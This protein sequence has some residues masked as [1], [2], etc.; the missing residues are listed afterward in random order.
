MPNKICLGGSFNP[1][2]HAHLLCARAAAEAVGAQVVVLM[3]AGVAPH[4]QTRGDVASCEDRLAMCNR[5][6]EH[7]RGFE[8]ADHEICRAGPSFT[9]Q[10]VRQL[11]NE[12]WTQVSWLIGADMLNTLPSWH[13]ATAL[14]EEARLLIM[15]RPGWTFDWDSLGPQFQSLRAQVVQVPQIDISATDIRRRVRDGLPIDCMT[16]PAVCRY[17]EDRKLYR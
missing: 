14:I 11:K 4:K 10:T 5:A 15:A 2:H 3:P 8:V 7:I 1:I 17:I 9:I 13:Q 12:G 16:P 6:I